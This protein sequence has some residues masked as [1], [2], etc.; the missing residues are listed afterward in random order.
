MVQSPGAMNMITSLHN[1]FILLNK[2][3]YK[4]R[5]IIP[6]GSSGVLE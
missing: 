6:E 2:H 1:P 3:M 4:I 5:E